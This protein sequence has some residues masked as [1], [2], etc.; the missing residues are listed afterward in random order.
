[1]RQSMAISVAVTLGAASLFAG[2]PVAGGITFSAAVNVDGVDYPSNTTIYA[3]SY[4]TQF[5]VKPVVQSGTY[6]FYG[7]FDSNHGGQVVYPDYTGTTFTLMPPPTVGDVVTF[8]LQTFSANHV[9]ADA[10]TTVPDPEQ[11]GTDLKPYRVLQAAV[12]AMLAKNK[13]YNLVLVKRGDYNEGGTLKTDGTSGWLASRVGVTQSKTSFIIRAVEGPAVTA[14]V[15]AK[16]T[17]SGEPAPFVGWGTNGVRCARLNSGSV[18]QGFTLRDGSGARNTATVTDYKNGGAVRGAGSTSS[19]V[20]D[21]V[22]SNACANVAAVDAATVI[23]CRFVD[24]HTRVCLL[25]DAPAYSSTFTGNELVEDGSYNY[26]NSTSP[27]RNCTFAGNV[28]RNGALP[29]TAHNSIFVDIQIVSG[30]EGGANNWAWNIGTGT[31]SAA[32]YTVQD[33]K[34]ADVADGDLRLGETSPCIGAIDAPTAANYGTNY[35]KTATSDVDGNRL[36]V[37]ADG[38]LTPGALQSEFPEAYAGELYVDPVNGLDT[39]DGWKRN[40]ALKTL[41]AAF[42]HEKCAEGTTVHVEPGVYDTGTMPS[43]ASAVLNRVSI[44]AG[45]ALVS[46]G[47]ATNTFLIGA[48]ATEDTAP[49]RCVH[50][51]NDSMIRGF[52]LTGGYTDSTENGAGAYASSTTLGARIYDC[53]I[54]N[55]VSGRRGGAASSCALYRCFVADNDALDNHT[56]TAITAGSLYNCI[57]G[58]QKS[59]GTR[60]YTTSVIRNCTFLPTIVPG[61]VQEAVNYSASVSSN[62]CQNSIFLCQTRQEADYRSCMIGTNAT[63]VGTRT[64]DPAVL[65][66]TVKLVTMAETLVREDGSLRCNSPAVNA[67]DNAL[68]D[69]AAWGDRDAK[70]GVRI[71]DGTIDMGAVEFDPSLATGLMVLVR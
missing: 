36:H 56:G 35:W 27:L 9:W 1:M 47:S 7:S 34:L 44:P 11:D 68:Y 18:L 42:T 14:I 54:T 69:A 45:V 23:R 4:P 10:N 25:S 41:T 46:L 40:R 65:G 52:T 21:C 16:D 48:P 32:A 13:N 63:D 2:E 30:T 12:D 22:I 26:F 71:C 29:G 39:N 59:S 67:G 37:A 62:Y 6:I 19:T 28:K 3:E 58:A 20:L 64:Y 8:G 53:I 17:I 5:V 60:C 43:D 70:G 15:G 49:T 57:I 31:P 51:H 50:M 24:N 38:K 33:P 61:Q 66:P 55:N